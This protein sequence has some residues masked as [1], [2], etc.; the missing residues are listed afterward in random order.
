MDKLSFEMC[1]RDHGT[2]RDRAYAHENFRSHAPSSLLPY[3]Y[4]C[5][6]FDIILNARITM[7]QS[8]AITLLSMIPL[9]TLIIPHLQATI[10]AAFSVL[11]IILG[12]YN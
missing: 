12:K 2:W 1:I 5:T 9:Y 10:V 7:L 8:C 6:L 4:D 3:N 11:S